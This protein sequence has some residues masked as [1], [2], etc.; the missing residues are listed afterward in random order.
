MTG[1][2]GLVADPTTALQAATKEYVDTRVYR[3]GNSLT[4]P[5]LLAG[6]PST[7]LQAATKAYVDACV[8]R[9]GDTMTG[10]LVLSGDP[11][12][13]L[14]AATRGYVD[15]QV[16]RSLLTSGGTMTGPLVLSEPFTGSGVR[17]FLTIA[18]AQSAVS[19]SPLVTSS[20]TLA[21]AGGAGA[22]NTNTQLTTNVGSSLNASGV[23]ADG[24]GTDVYSLVSSMN[25]SALCPLGASATV[26]QQVS[27]QSAPTRT[28]PPGGVPVGR[29]MVDVGSPAASRR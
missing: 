29:Q 10:L 14:G 11:A 5:L 9:S 13:T 4:G 22:S 26:A 25:S 1:P 8:A 23:A 7:A 18:R 12:G 28:L 20:M 6:A 27:M 3:A 16:A 21:F 24:P 2:L 19:D 15:G 17:T